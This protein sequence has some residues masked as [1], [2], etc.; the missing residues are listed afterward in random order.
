MS[1]MDIQITNNTNTAKWHVW[2]HGIIDTAL[3]KQPSQELISMINTINGIN[4]NQAL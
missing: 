3:F 2:A 4:F 1:P